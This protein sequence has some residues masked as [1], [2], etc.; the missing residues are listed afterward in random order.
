MKNLY[1]FYV[2][3]LC[4]VAFPLQASHIMGCDLIYQ[5]LGGNQYRIKLTQYRD[6]SGILPSNSVSISVS[7]ALCSQNFS[8]TANLDTGYPIEVSA[9]CGSQL[10][11]T[12]CN[13]G[14][15]PGVQEYVYSVITTLP[16]NCSDWKF[17]W[18]DGNRN[19]AISTISSP[20]SAFIYI[21]ATLNNL[22]FSGNNSPDFITKPVPYFGLNQPQNYSHSTVEPDGDVLVYSL[23]APLDNST[24]PVTFLSPYSATYPISTTS[25]T[26]PFNTTT[27]Q[28]SF[29]PNAIQN[30]VTAILVQEYR[31]G[32]LIGSVR[33]DIQMVVLNMT[34]GS[35]SATPPTNIAGANL[36]AGQSSVFNACVGTTM[37]FKVTASDPN[38][39]TVI[40]HTSNNTT[41][42][43]GSSVSVSGTN[44]KVMTFSWTPTAADIGTNSFSVTFTDNNCP[45]PSIIALN[46]VIYVLGINIT[47]TDTSICNLGGSLQLSTAIFGAGSGNYAWTGTG[48]SANNIPNPIVTPS[49]LPSLYTVS[50]TLSG[51]NVTDHISIIQNTTKVN[52]FSTDSVVCTTKPVTLNTSINGISGGSYSWSGNGLSSSNAS[53]TIATPPS[54]PQTYSVTYTTPGGGCV[55][56]DNVTI[57]QSNILVTTTTAT[58]SSICLGGGPVQLN[59][60]PTASTSGYSL[61]S[62]P[63]SPIAGTGT[64]VTLSDDELS[65]ALPIGF[66]FNF[67]GTIYSNFHISS[68]GY[69]SFD[70]S[71]GAGCCS[72][73]I[74]PNTSSPNNL[75]ALNW[76][77]LYPPAGGTISYLLTGTAPFRK[78]VINYTMIN[79]CC[80]V[81]ASLDVTGQIILYE[82][83]N[84]IEI[85]ATDIGATV[86]QTMGIEN[87]NGTSAVVVAGRNSTT[88]SALNEGWR[89][90]P[91]TSYTYNWSPTTNMNSA[92]ISNPLISTLTTDTVYTVVVTSSEGCSGTSSVTIHTGTA[93]SASAT[94]SAS[95]SSLCAGN[96]S[97][98]QLNASPVSVATYDG[99][100]PYTV[101][102]I[103]HAPL[104]GTG[105]SV[106]L[107]DDQVSA[108]LPI[109][110]S[111]TFYGNAYTNF[112]I[113][114]NGFITF[115]ASSPS[116]CCSGQLL[117]NSTTPNNVIAIAW[118]DFYP[119]G[120]G[121][122]NY[123]TTG[124]APNRK[125]IV[126]YT[127]IPRCCGSV[128]D[129]TGQIVL[130]EG[131]NWIDIFLTNLGATGTTTLG[132]E[133]ATGTL[134]TAVSGRNAA[135][136]G[137]S[138]EG[139]R[140][141]SGT[142]ATHTYLWSPSTNLSSTSIYNPIV[143]SLAA[144]TTYTVQ[145][146][147]LATGCVVNKPVT[148]TRNAPITPVVTPTNYCNNANL[149]VANAYSGT[150]QWYNNNTASGAPLGT[151]SP[152]STTTNGTYY[153]FENLGGC[154]GGVS[155]PS[156]V[157]VGMSNLWTHI[158]NPAPPISSTQSYYA[159]SYCF[160]PVSGLNYFF[161]APSH[162]LI[163]ASSY[164]LPTGVSLVNYAPTLASEMAVKVDVLPGY[165][166]GA[167]Q[168]VNYGTAPYVTNPSGWY[169]MHRTWNVL[170]H[171]N[172]QISA[173]TRNIR[174]FFNTIDET[175]VS[176][177]SGH[178]LSTYYFYKLETGLNPSSPANH[179][180]V[181]SSQI[182]LYTPGA[183]PTATEWKL[184]TDLTTGAYYSEYGVS[185]FSGGGGGSGIIFEGPLPLSLLSFTGRN[186]A[187]KNL[188]AWQVK[189]EINLS[190]YELER[191][192]DQTH[193]VKIGQQLAMNHDKYYLLD[194]KPLNGNNYYRL[195]MID[196]DGKY[197]Y[198]EIVL[199]NNASLNFQ[200]SIAP[201]PAHQFIDLQLESLSG[202]NLVFSLYNEL[203]QEV[204][205]HTWTDTGNIRK[206]LDISSLTNGIYLYK[207]HDSHTSYSGKL[208]KE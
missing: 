83:T 76:D 185:S 16:A 38:A 93:F 21:E 26:F 171:P 115:N 168:F 15:V 2:L 23:V 63:F 201:N 106:S 126:N 97:P 41:A 187:N 58:P 169:L 179:A 20:G 111:F 77:D 144:T 203:G 49:S 140:F 159:D 172:N 40:T 163:L 6:C 54:L 81:N 87:A 134:A 7:S 207:I 162:T 137:A 94:A 33:R 138:N 57:I 43:P 37:T 114:S 53:S 8:L 92:T 88:W 98:I 149:A 47:N 29:T 64:T 133:N 78:L 109:G 143:S 91:S 10:P 121:S 32:V 35:S 31:G 178:N 90:T 192:E 156:T 184:G 50:Y 85:H 183:T 105:T 102:T 56:T 70:P 22:N 170:V 113:S 107:S 60:Q 155:N 200:F 139:W 34:N 95:P 136:W 198:S 175:D 204:I 39:A 157:N 1:F 128:G 199:L 153:A 142:S 4:F 190:H 52:A 148:L 180:G 51:C 59:A 36:V 197:Q 125:L 161:H 82:T 44:P 195:K 75:I 127:N 188:L 191:A 129:L 3:V 206:T 101:N 103:P 86:S 13:G 208:L 182:S 9:I 71:A 108:A 80:G 120:N 131:T 24:T 112:Y 110:F 104:S 193:F 68:N 158:P 28:M 202:D 205:Q 14:T 74:L 27:G 167:G 194:E 73:Q 174:F 124:T 145:V 146:T 151:G 135:T 173:G 17:S 196:N 100:G 160:D 165:A 152:I 117:P 96:N 55:S 66:N 19:S 42:L 89:F 181:V 25:G 99:N 11:N 130:Y 122:I 30:A 119:P 186:E 154:L 150:I 141:Y 118:A 62:I 5:H 61:T 132:I 18:Y 48:L 69:V 79:A 166:S 177:S 164:M 189:D 84:V 65:A 12:T 176:N 46:Y 123:Y 67:Y 147:D 72:G 116:G 45:I